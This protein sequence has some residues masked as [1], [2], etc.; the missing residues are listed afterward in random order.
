MLATPVQ[1]AQEQSDNAVFDALLWSLSRPGQPRLLPHKGEAQIVSALLDRECRVHAN[2]P[3]LMP[4]VLQTGAEVAEIEDADHL[5]LGSLTDI[6]VLD[7]VSQ[8]TDLYPD[9]G[10]TIILRAKI[11]QGPRL[12][13][14][15]PGIDGSL[16]VEI[17]GLPNGFWQR[18]SEVT[19]YPMGFELFI[20]D[21]NRVLGIPRSTTIEVF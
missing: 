18:R 15:G 12:R 4:V 1:T 11:G 6:A 10:A 20:L 14:A 8:G 19:R 16:S 5:F 13:L 2:D 3:L 9:D 7:R 21:E 17:G